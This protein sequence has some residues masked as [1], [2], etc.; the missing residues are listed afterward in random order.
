MGSQFGSAR[1]TWLLKDG[2]HI[3][4]LGNHAITTNTQ[5][6]LLILIDGVTTTELSVHLCKI[7]LD[8]V[9]LN[10]CLWAHISHNVRLKKLLVT[11]D[12]FGIVTVKFGHVDCRVHLGSNV[13]IAVIL[14]NGPSERFALGATICLLQT[15]V[16]IDCG[17]CLAACALLSR[18]V[19][20]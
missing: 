17:I 16:T 8:Q 11:V 15:N 10:H 12:A 13:H 3:D 7:G 14:M 1:I 5:L 19:F 20:V 6:V 4:E 2:N 18:H 9:L